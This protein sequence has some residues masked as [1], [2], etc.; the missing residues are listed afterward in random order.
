[1]RRSG[2]YPPTSR[3]WHYLPYASADV[4]HLLKQANLVLDRSG[5]QTVL[6]VADGYLR[7]IVGVPQRR[8]GSGFGR[9]VHES[10]RSAR[11]QW[12]TGS[13]RV[14]QQGGGP[15]FPCQVLCVS[16]DKGNTSFRGHR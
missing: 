4:G 12:I 1:M 2:G 3:V 7:Q 5:T 14:P 15:G 13:T 11:D 10:V 6:R 8:G 16:R 9:Q